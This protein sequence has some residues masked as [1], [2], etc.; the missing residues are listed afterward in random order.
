MHGHEISSNRISFDA[1]LPMPALVTKLLDRAETRGNPKAIAAIKA[2]GR[3]FADAVTWLEHSVFEKHDLMSSAK[4]ARNNIHTGE[5]LC[6]C[7]SK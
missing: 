4:Q 7:T 1:A 2:E 5:F 6:I 3:A